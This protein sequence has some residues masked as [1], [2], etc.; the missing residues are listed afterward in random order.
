MPLFELNIP[1]AVNTD[2][3]DPSWV[4]GDLRRVNIQMSLAHPKQWIFNGRV[5]MAP[6]VEQVR[7]IR[8]IPALPCWRPLGRMAALSGRTVVPEFSCRWPRK[9]TQ[10]VVAGVYEA[11]RAVGIEPAEALRSI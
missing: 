3:V 7:G 11:I 9:R 10:R 2:T 1:Y 4:P 5:V 8:L 6:L